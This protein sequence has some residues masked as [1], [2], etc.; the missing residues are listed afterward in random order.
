[1]PVF[2]PLRTSALTNISALK[3]MLCLG[4]PDSLRFLVCFGSWNKNKTVAVK[5]PI[6]LFG[7]ND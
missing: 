6:N 4:N 5:N 7:L 1:M 3:S 2:P